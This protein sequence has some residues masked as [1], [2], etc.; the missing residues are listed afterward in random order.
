MEKRFNILYWNIN[1]RSGSYVS[2][3][4]IKDSSEIIIKELQESI[5]S[6]NRDINE[7]IHAIVFTEAYPIEKSSSLIKSLNDMEYTTYP[8]DE[9]F[10][11]YCKTISEKEQESIVK[12]KNG[13]KLPYASNTKKYQNG[14]LIAISR[15][16]VEENKIKS[17]KIAERGYRRDTP[18]LLAIELDDLVIC[19]VR[20]NQGGVSGNEKLI[21]SIDND[22][23]HDKKCGKWIID[24][25][26]GFR[27]V[28]N[29]KCM[30][31]SIVRRAAYEQFLHIIKG[32][33]KP[34]IAIGDFN[35][36]NSKKKNDN[37]KEEY[38]YNN[39][40]WKY[41]EIIENNPNFNV[42]NGYT[43]GNEKMDYLYLKNC[44]LNGKKEEN[45]RTVK[46]MKC[47]Y[48]NCDN[49]IQNIFKEAIE[50][51]PPFPDH[52]LLFAS[53]EIPEN[54]H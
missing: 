11:E 28:K 33:D 41:T 27:F 53:I 54:N 20:I 32:F 45:F 22:I 2:D 23:P 42:C 43:I 51:K 21:L 8:S 37:G 39:A 3:E 24:D 50:I 52:N 26:D 18:N 34:V 4:S 7:K 46:E 13:K 25:K 29:D 15:K 49:D 30:N 48:G 16:Y 6:I 44:H 31:T 40:V 19:G 14:V 17:I 38:Q 35:I 9:S 12:D 10:E 1:Y 47:V 5:K 36:Y